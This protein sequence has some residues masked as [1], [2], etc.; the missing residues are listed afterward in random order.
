MDRIKVVKVVVIGGGFSGCAAAISAI[1]AAAEVVLLER[2]DML[3]GAG[4]RAGRMNYNGKLV[5]AEEAKALGCGEIFEALESILLHR[6]NIVDEEHGYVYDTA[7]VDP[8]MRKVM[9]DAGAEICLEGRAIDVQKRDGLVEAIILDGG[10]RLSG[11]VFMD[12][13]GGEGG[14]DI[15]TRYGGGCVMCL[16]RCLSFGNRVSIATKAG[17]PEL[18]RRR[19]DGKIGSA[20]SGMTVFKESLSQELRTRLAKEGAIS[21]PL[22]KHLINYSLKGD[23]GGV[24]SRRQMEYINLVD[25]GLGA[26]CPGF[27]HR[28]LAELRSIPGFEYAMVESPIGGN[29]GDMIGKVSM[30]PRDNSL[31]V[32]GFSNLFVAGEKAGPGTGVAETII[33]GIMA[34]NNA[35]RKV[36]AKKPLLL[37][38]TTTIGDFIAYTGEM[39]TT[40]KD[41]SQGYSMGHG[42]YFERMKELGL[43]TPDCAAI[44]KRIEQLGLVGILREKVTV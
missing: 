4:L 15:C 23:I 1:K 13:T 7:K 36:A 34:G 10:E 25:S 22:P 32:K 35:V 38:R 28:S 14:L 18:M 29:K 16:Y 17:A 21:I 40:E 42:I 27:G 33:T 5:A 26:K 11:D 8:I 6:G 37:P 3:S 31:L 41:W 9:R 24:R 19:P 43:Y 20:G 39:M 44:H 30:T 2:T 12:A